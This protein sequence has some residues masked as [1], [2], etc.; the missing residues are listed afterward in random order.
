MPFLRLEPFHHW[1]LEIPYME[2]I[3]SDVKALAVIRQTQTNSE[4]M[5]VA[6]LMEGTFLVSAL[7]CYSLALGYQEHFCP[8]VDVI[9]G[10]L[11]S[12]AVILGL[13]VLVQAD[14]LGKTFYMHWVVEES[15][16][17]INLLFQGTFSGAPRTTFLHRTPFA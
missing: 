17:L 5:M 16:E 9:F 2:N 15:P 3:W 6:N 13:R 4:F 10:N 11:K 8:F 7:R 14:I 1:F 12:I